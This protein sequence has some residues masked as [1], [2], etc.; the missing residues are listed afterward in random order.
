MATKFDGAG[1][2][3]LNGVG[4]DRGQ[5]PHFVFGQHVPAAKGAAD[6]LRRRLLGAAARTVPF[7]QG[8]VGDEAVHRVGH[9]GEPRA[10]P[11][12]AVGVHVE[13]DLPL[14][15]DGLPDGGV[16]ARPQFAQVDAAVG[17]GRAR[18]QEFR[19]T[20]QA[21]DLFGAKGHRYL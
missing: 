2:V 1:M 16:L 12:F 4:A 14:Q 9:A 15:I 8:A 6:D 17:V 18:S 20:Q 3:I 11:H 13:A 7:E 21:P 10:A 5:E 19:R